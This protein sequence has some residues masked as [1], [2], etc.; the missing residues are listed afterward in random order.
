M[1]FRSV[2]GVTGGGIGFIQP[3]YKARATAWLQKNLDDPDG[4]EILDWTE[5]KRPLK[6]STAPE[7]EKEELARYVNSAVKYRAK[8]KFGTK[9]IRVTKLRIYDS[10]DVDELHPL[11]PLGE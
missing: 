2:P 8:N 11:H 10:G 3:D 5:P 9:E 4:L 6:K 1:V 7:A